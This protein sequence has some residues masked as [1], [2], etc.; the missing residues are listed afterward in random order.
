MS[1]FKIH[2]KNWSKNCILSIED[3][4]WK[5]E[6]NSVGSYIELVTPSPVNFSQSKWK[7]PWIKD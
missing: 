1:Q 4:F 5:K 6:N 2:N 7:I 3:R